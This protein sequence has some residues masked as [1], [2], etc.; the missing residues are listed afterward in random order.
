MES[1]N[2]QHMFYWGTFLLQWVVA[3]VASL[4]PLLP[5]WLRSLVVHSHGHAVEEDLRGL[6]ASQMHRKLLLNVFFMSMDE[7]RMVV[8]PDVP[9]LRSQQEKMVLYYV[10]TDGWVPLPF[11]EEI[12]KCCPRLRAWILEDD[13]AVPHAWCLQ[14]TDAVVKTIASYL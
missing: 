13:V 12:K 8:R 9:L 1:P 2:G 7:F 5:M 11:A 3:F 4:F 6:L 14:H 10:K